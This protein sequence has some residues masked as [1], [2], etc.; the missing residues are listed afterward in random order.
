MVFFVFKICRLNEYDLVLS[1]LSTELIIATI[2]YKQVTM[3]DEGYKM[4]IHRVQERWHQ[5]VPSLPFF[6]KRV[7]QRDIYKPL[8]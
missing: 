6:L 1:I 7:C 4:V 8:P 5:L 2:C 3:N